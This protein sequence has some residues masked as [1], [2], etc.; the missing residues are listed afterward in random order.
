[1]VPTKSSNLIA[2]VPFPVLCIDIGGTTTTAAIVQDA[3]SL[4]YLNSHSTPKGIQG[5]RSV[6]TSIWDAAVSPELARVVIAMPGKRLAGEPRCLAPG[7]AENIG[8]PSDRPFEFTELVDGIFPDRVHCD[9]LNDA[10]AQCIGGIQLL[11][12]AGQQE[13]LNQKLLYLGIGTGLGSAFA[14]TDGS[15]IHSYTDGHVGDMRITV[16]GAQDAMAEALCS[17]RAFFAQRGTP[18]SQAASHLCSDDIACI[19]QMGRSLGHIIQ[20]IYLGDIQKNEQRQAWSQADKDAVAGTRHVLLGGSIGTQDPVATI[21]QESAAQYLQNVE[22]PIR[23]F[24]VSDP[25]H[26]A[27]LGAYYYSRG[28]GRGAGIQG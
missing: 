3:Q 7:S 20:Q 15:H 18:L 21:I 22:L 11:L 1:M 16:D 13:I 17:G 26:A 25:D 9:I 2:I 24:R 28:F 19:Q 5:L 12:D 4:R 8:L 23:F 10:L 6:L 27:I 14:T